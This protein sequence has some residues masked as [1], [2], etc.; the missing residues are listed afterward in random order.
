MTRPTGSLTR[1]ALSDD[2]E[3]HDRY[4]ERGPLREVAWD[5]AA[6][7]SSLVHAADVSVYSGLIGR[8]EWEAAK[9]D[10]GVELAIVGSWHGTSANRYAEHVLSGARMAGLMTATYIVL[11]VHAW[12]VGSGLKACG[13]QADHLSFVAL[14]C[15]LRGLTEDSLHE[16]IRMVQD[17]GHRCVIYTGA[18]VL[19]GTVGQPRVGAAHA[20]LGQPLRRLPESL[21]ADRNRLRRL[22]GEAHRGSSTRAPTPP[23]GSVLI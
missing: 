5:P 21:R 14:D 23:S 8:P 11:D 20:A 3:I 12:V 7:V 1:P 13:M 17:A 4:S 9:E 2:G 6:D 22:E 16:A 19:G 15:E 18:V 10:H